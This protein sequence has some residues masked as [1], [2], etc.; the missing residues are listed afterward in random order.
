MLACA[1]TFSLEGVSPRRVCAEVDV[2]PGL[3]AFTVVGMGDRAVR[4]SRERVR[5]AI[6]N[7]GWSFPQ[8][9]VTVNLAPAD[10]RKEGPGFDLAVAC[11][12]LAATGEVAPECLV[13]VA[14]LGE[15]ALDGRLRPCR[16]AIAA[17]EGAVSEGLRSII[18][19]ADQAHDVGAVEGLTVLGARTLNEV[20]AVLRG[21]S[22]GFAPPRTRVQAKAL[23]LPDLRDVRGQSAA[24]RALS[25]AAA[26]GHHMLLS[27][28][29]GT[30]KTMLARRLPGI[31]PAL[32]RTEELEV[33]R[34]RSVTGQSTA[35]VVQRPFRS[36]HH[37]ISAAGLVGGGTI[38]TPG[39]VTLAHRGVLF[40]DEL[41]EFSRPA[42]EALR[43]PLEARELT[44]VR[45]QRAVRF[46]A[47]VQIVAATNPCPC[48][49][50]GSPRCRCGEAEVE[51]YRRRLSGPLVDRLDVRLDLQRPTED[52]LA[53]APATSSGDV[54]REVE[55][56]VA[57]RHAAGRGAVKN[58]DLSPAE[59]EALLL[60]GAATDGLSRA[61]RRGLLSP[62]ARGRVLR[63]ARTIADLAQSDEVDLVHVLEALALNPST[64]SQ[65]VAA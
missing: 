32:S 9:R 35:A 11:A 45:G 17:A 31:L 58:A 15:L 54:R 50:H 30:G 33:R 48:G 1:Q 25:I 6:A 41:A 59:L 21:E 61:Y 19:P 39:E 28:P 5:A 24:V 64:G 55:R 18:V 27:G 12:V 16:G 29:P 42:V 60:S 4:E 57:F 13:N 14:I 8:Q 20:V 47:A 22:A 51:R 63:V 2:R 36:P 46:P 65:R 10:M 37:T 56:A 26:G 43:Q 62:R 49:H 23:D 40:L 52:E 44:V 3:P 53:A 7:C 38:P 34:I